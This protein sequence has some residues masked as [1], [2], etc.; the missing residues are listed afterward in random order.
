MVN[1]LM[2]V[3]YFNNIHDLNLIPSLLKD[4]PIGMDQVYRILVFAIH[5]EGVTSPDIEPD[6]LFDRVG[7]AELVDS[8][9][10]LL[11]H[12]RAV[13]SCRGGSVGTHF[14]DGST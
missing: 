6:H 7:R 8:H 3:N 11:G 9:T 10:D 13:F 12:F 1:D 5:S 4:Q 2:I 14:F